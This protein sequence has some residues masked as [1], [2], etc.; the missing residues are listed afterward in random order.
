MKFSGLTTVT[1][2]PSST[3]RRRCIAE[4]SPPN[5]A[6][7]TRIRLRVMRSMLR[8]AATSARDDRAQRVERLGIAERGPESDRVV[9]QPVAVRPAG[10]DQAELAGEAPVVLDRLGR[11]VGV[12]D[13][14][15]AHAGLGHRSD[16]RVR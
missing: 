15:P 5:P 16:Q 12:V 14:E 7:T 8:G 13:L 11:V 1:R 4:Y 10:R 2:W 6:P 9:P 3:A